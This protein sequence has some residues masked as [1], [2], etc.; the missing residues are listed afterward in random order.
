VVFLRV[1][2]QHEEDAVKRAIILA[3]AGI[4]C[5]AGCGTPDVKPNVPATPKWKG[6]PYR[7][8]FDTK[9]PKPNPA[10]VTVPTIRF[11]ANPE[12]LE[13]RAT[14]VLRFDSTVVTKDRPVINQM[15]MAP[16]DISGEDGALSAD[17]MN[18]VDKEL[19]SLLGSY[20]VKGKVKISVALARSS[21]SMQAG[22]GEINNKRL[23]DWI[24]TEVVFKNPHRGC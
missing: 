8:A 11:T 1:V 21:L 23:S 10:G 20:C 6:A 7:I 13:T 17:Y 19:A 18:A 9:A 5:L 12:M 24:P 14:L 16:A 2:L 4:L 15:I 3:I 22:E